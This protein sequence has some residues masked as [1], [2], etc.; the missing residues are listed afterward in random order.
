MVKRE[1]YL[2]TMALMLER[3]LAEADFYKRSGALSMLP[4][5]PLS[6]V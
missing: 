1:R 6:L 5:Y 2:P 3:G 4:Y